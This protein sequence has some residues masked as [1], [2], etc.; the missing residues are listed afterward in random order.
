MENRTDLIEVQTA[1]GNVVMPAAL[2]EFAANVESEISRAINKEG[3]PPKTVADELR[4]LLALVEEGWPY[5]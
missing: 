1:D 4:T 2:L 3:L 5:S